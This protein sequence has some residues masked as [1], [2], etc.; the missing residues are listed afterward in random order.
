MNKSYRQYRTLYD[1]GCMNNF[2]TTNPYALS[3]QD[4][5]NKSFNNGV[6]SASYNQNDKYSQAFISQKCA[7]NWDEICELAADSREPAI[8]SLGNQGNYYYPN[9]TT[10]G[11]VTLRN[12]AMERFF[13]RQ[14]CNAVHER[15]N[16]VDSTSPIIKMYTGD[17]ELMCILKLDDLDRDPVL[18]KMLRRE[19]VKYIDIFMKIYDHFKSRG[20][21]LR[22]TDTKLGNFLKHYFID[23]A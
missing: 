17:C 2:I 1:F 3:L 15:L 8:N 11:E 10:L 22:R 18:N 9:Y 4:T 23:T 21:D 7:S 13:I 20:V 12:T 19:P 6:T 5:I 14:N 16:P